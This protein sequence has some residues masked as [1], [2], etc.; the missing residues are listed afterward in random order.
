M[1]WNCEGLLQKLCAG[2]KI[3]SFLCSIFTQHL[4]LLLFLLPSSLSQVWATVLNPMLIKSLSSRCPH[5]SEE[6]VQ[7]LG[8]LLLLS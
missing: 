5:F 7:L 3:T 4:M 2:W 6:K 1:R 8:P